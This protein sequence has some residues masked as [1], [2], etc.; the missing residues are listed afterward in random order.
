MGDNQLPKKV[1]DLVDQ[2]AKESGL[3]DYTLELKSGSNA[4]DG[5][6]SA[7][8]AV[9][10]VESNS[11]KSL[12]LVIKLAPTNVIHRKEFFTDLMFEHET[13]Y[14]NVVAPAFEKF[15]DEKNVPKE[16]QFLEYPKCYFAVADEK[17]EEYIVVLEDL[18]P[19]GFKQWDKTKPA[20]IE[21]ARLAMRTI[22]KFHAI[23]VAYKD[24]KPEEFVKLKT[25]QSQVSDIYK[26]AFSSETLRGMLLTSFDR[27]IDA[28]KEDA[29]K[30][31]LREIKENYSEHF[32]QILDES[33]KF[34]VVAHGDFYN[35]NYLFRFNEQVSILNLLNTF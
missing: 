14:Y 20:P 27:T 22:G 16:D 31:I 11:D 8:T 34:A 12:E 19:K 33:N 28:M 26:I 17:T 15:Q 24:Q 6:A 13:F 9:K 3:K 10:I 1:Q 7:L 21:N 5:F 23:S 30:D 32:T 25:I 2:I 4:G 18:R 35:N 29:H